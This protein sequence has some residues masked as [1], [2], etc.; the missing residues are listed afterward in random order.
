VLG[1]RSLQLGAILVVCAN[2]WAAHLLP[3]LLQGR[4]PLP[5]VNLFVAAATVIAGW[6]L[7]RSAPAGASALLLCLPAALPP[8]GLAAWLGLLAATCLAA[9]ADAPGRPGLLPEGR[10]LVLEPGCS[11][12]AVMA[13]ALLGWVALRVWHGQTVRPAWPL[14]L[15]A[16]LIGL[17]TVRLLVMTFDENWYRWAHQG[18]GASVADA[19]AVLLVFAVAAPGRSGGR[20]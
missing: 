2:G 19:V 8:S 3:S 9:S 7:L 12:L 1:D 13:P 14:A 15:A 4:L 16:A 18:A 17:N 6:R 20:P 10:S 11:F 5:P